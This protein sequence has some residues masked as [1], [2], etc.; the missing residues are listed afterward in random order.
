[1][2]RSR[3][4]VLALLTAGLLAGAAPAD[5]ANLRA[6][7][8]RAD[9]TPRTGFYL[10]GWTRAD[11][12]AKGQQTRLWCRAMVLE[13]DGRKVALVAVDLFLI[14]GGLVKHVGDALADRGF[15]DR[16]ILISASHTHSGPGGFANYPT[17]NTAAPS[18]GTTGDPTTFVRLFDP[19][20]ADR[21]LYTFLVKQI[22]AAIR[23]ADRDRGPAVAGWGQ[24]HLS[25]LTRNRSLEAHLAD[26]GIIREYGQGSVSEDPGGYE[27]TIDPA[28]NV[29]RVDKLVRRRGRRKRKRKRRRVPIGAWSTFAAHGTV[30]KSSFQYYNQDHHGSAIGVFEDRVRRA[31]RVPRRQQ[32]LNVFG[33]TNEGDISAGLDRHGPA[34]S[35]YVGRVEA[36]AMLRA[37]R[38]AG[39]GLT[40]TPLL[41]LRWTR[42]CFCGQS[43]KGGNVA[44]D[45]AVGM[46]FF[47][48]SEEERGPLYDVTHEHFEGRRNPVALGPHGHKAGVEGVPGDVPHAVPLLAVRVGSRM[49]VSVP[50][51][52]TK[53]VGHR[54]RHAV[55]A[56]VAG[57]GIGRVVVSGLANEYISYFTTPEEYDRQHYEGGQTWFGR[58]SSVLL[59]DHLAALAGR[60]VR[61]QPAQ[62]PHMIDPT[63]GV[64]PDGPPFG[65]GAASGA[66]E[67]Q[68]GRFYRRFQQARLS[69]RGG[70]LGLDRPVDR[71]FVIV[72]RRTRRRWRQVTSDL[73][74]QILW[75]VD[76]DGRYQARWE[77]PRNARRGWYRIVVRAKRYTLTS[78]RFGVL[79]SESLVLER[80]A[81]PPGRVAVRMTYPPPVRDRNLAYRPR[82]PQGGRVIFVVGDRAV[83]VRRRRSAIFS[84]RAP[85]GVPVRVPARAAR[86]RSLNV[87]RRGLRLRG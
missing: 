2:T 48:G 58:M 43:V 21:Q 34:A 42:M 85:A 26:H 4:V 35:D 66:I 28:V 8:G 37:W 9:I 19:K 62:T 46:P 32:V 1:V 39:R 49:I 20:P 81:A 79:R 87:A 24:E 47:T 50:G 25:G 36:A 44:S 68:P 16:N 59:Q 23:R 12:V 51:E 27:H 41:D 53:E 22:S 63:H 83:R 45:P 7:V 18:T 73:G 56:A 65:D 52:A 15:S 78:R 69:W 33:N 54:I 29:L 14:P 17:F 57:R 61:G 84:V 80:V 55:E 40:R 74:L 67:Q 6:G 3:I 5:A 77:I 76:S 60:L 71:A 75:T 13:R 38:Q 72:Q 30:T 31:G 86:D 64:R 11:R 10:G 82:H 70:R